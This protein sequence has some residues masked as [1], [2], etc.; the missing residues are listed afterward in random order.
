MS[1]IPMPYTSA[2]R[3]N[4][5]YTVPRKKLE[6]YVI[7][8]MLVTLEREGTSVRTLAKKLPVSASTLG[9]YRQ[10]THPPHPEVVRAL[11]ERVDEATPVP[12]AG[13]Q[14]GLVLLGYDTPWDGPKTKQ[15]RWDTVTLEIPQQHRLVKGEDWYDRVLAAGLQDPDKAEIVAQHPV[16]DWIERVTKYG[17]DARAQRMGFQHARLGILKRYQTSDRNEW[18]PSPRQLVVLWRAINPSS[19]AWMRVQF[20]PLDPDHIRFLGNLAC[21]LGP[22]WNYA[23][24]CRIDSAFDRDGRV[25]D[26][27]PWF[28]GRT[29]WES[30]ADPAGD[31][32]EMSIAVGDRGSKF[33]LRVYDRQTAGGPAVFRS[34]LEYKPDSKDRPLLRQ[35]DQTPQPGAITI[36]ILDLR[37]PMLTPRDRVLLHGVARLGWREMCQGSRSAKRELDDLRGRIRAVGGVHDLSGELLRFWSTGLMLLKEIV[38]KAP[39]GIGPWNAWEGDRG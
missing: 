10:G 22:L 12:P 36:Q 27:V 39:V 24:L 33:Y 17:D 35:L 38:I 29:K 23:R 37:A 21:H 13:L 16:E 14:P 26:H 28:P 6:A 20:C 7:D 11:I 25:Q 15:F 34:E 3:P 18:E 31:G 8:L 4:V 19:P 32:H 9:N 1:S 30:R 2:Q 5:A